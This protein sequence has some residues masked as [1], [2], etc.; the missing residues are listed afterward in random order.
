MKTKHFILF[1]IVFELMQIMDLVLTF[2]ALKI[3]GNFEVNPLYHE[4]IF[5]PLKLTIPLFVTGIMYCVRFF[6]KGARFIMGANII[7]YSFIIINNII[8]LGA[9]TWE[10]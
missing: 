10:R 6:N 7:I 3:P 9:A 1:F 2:H 5:I 8:M 4:P